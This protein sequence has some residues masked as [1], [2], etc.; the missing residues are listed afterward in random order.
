MLEGKDSGLVIFFGCASPRSRVN[1]TLQRIG[2][3]PLGPTLQPFQNGDERDRIKFP[4]E[5]SACID[6]HSA[7]A[8]GEKGRVGL[9]IHFQHCCLARFLPPTKDSR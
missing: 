6:P 9:A 4:I 5:C 1:L 3:T 2:P 8:I 7:K